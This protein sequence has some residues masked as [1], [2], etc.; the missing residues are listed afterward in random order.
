VDAGPP[1][2][3]AAASLPIGAAFRAALL[4]KAMLLLGIAA[5]FALPALRIATGSGLWPLRVL[6]G[7]FLAVLGAYVAWAGSLGIRDAVAGRAERVAGAVALQSRR[8]GYSLRLPDG[9]FVELILWNPWQPLVPGR[10]YTVTF[11]RHSRVLVRPPEP[12]E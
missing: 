6:V 1:P 7:L 10:R 2:P 12:E 8:A 4:G 3:P 11:G 9:S 5:L